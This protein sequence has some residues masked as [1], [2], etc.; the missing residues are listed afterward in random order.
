MPEPQV[1]EDNYTR[2][3]LRAH[4]CIV[5]WCRCQDY[6]LVPGDDWVGVHAQLAAEATIGDLDAND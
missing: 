4:E 6:E 3:E 2:T 5:G 1:I